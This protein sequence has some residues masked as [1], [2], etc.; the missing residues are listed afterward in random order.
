MAPNKISYCS[1]KAV[2]CFC[3]V[4]DVDPLKTET[5]VLQSVMIWASIFWCLVSLQLPHACQQYIVKLHVHTGGLFTTLYWV[6]LFCV[7][8]DNS[9]VT[10]LLISLV[11]CG[12]ISSNSPF[13]ISET[14]LRGF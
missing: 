8:C 6:R 12:L 2:V 10:R 5:G 7:T 9:I 13:T 4:K 1:Y 3:G 11:Y 14:S